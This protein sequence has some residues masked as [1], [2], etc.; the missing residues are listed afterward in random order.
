MWHGSAVGSAANTAIDRPS[1]LLARFTALTANRINS[2]VKQQPV[3]KLRSAAPLLGFALPC[4]AM[5]GPSSLSQP[6]LHSPV[7]PKLFLGCRR[8]ENSARLW[9]S[10]V[11]L[12]PGVPFR[13][14]IS[15]RSLCDKAAAPFSC[16]LTHARKE[17]QNSPP[18]S[19]VL[20]QV[21]GCS[22]FGKSG[23]G[24]MALR[25]VEGDLQIAIWENVLAPLALDCARTCSLWQNLLADMDTAAG[26]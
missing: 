3:R 25:G 14:R 19:L 8:P 6:P 24:C 10:L 18:R 20:L 5:P 2:F 9:A 23:P 7:F 17:T 1:S 21:P 11:R 26:L 22:S 12:S 15:H 16:R 13:S 4:L